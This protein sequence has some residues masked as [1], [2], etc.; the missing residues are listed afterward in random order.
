[1]RTVPVF[2]LDI[3]EEVTQGNMAFDLRG[4]LKELRIVFDPK[5]DDHAVIAVYTEGFAVQSFN[6]Q[7]DEV[8]DV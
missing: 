5:D 8:T 1:M 4:R 3:V 7:L 2:L 6:L